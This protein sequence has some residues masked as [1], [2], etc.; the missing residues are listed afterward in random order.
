MGASATFFVLGATAI[1]YPH[2]IRAIADR[3]HEVACHGFWHDR[4]FAQTEA[5]FREDVEACAVLLEELTGRRPRGYR[6]PAFSI[7]SSTAWA[8]E[9]LADLGFEYD[10]SQYDSPRV[11][12]RHRAI[13]EA[14]Y[15]LRLPS[16]R[17]LWELPIATWR[18]G[19]RV[20]PIGGGSYWRLLPAAILK[21]ALRGASREGAPPMLYFHPYECDPRPLRAG[22]PPSA[23]PKARA[24]ALAWHLWF[25]PGRSRIV[26]R[27]ERLAKDFRLVGF[28][29]VREEISERYGA[30]TRSLSQG[31]VLV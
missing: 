14:P 25:N 29:E 26:P 1:H 28:E 2:A 3:G 19:E 21:R 6:A 22:V 4:V 15:R 17:E 7:T 31:G 30:G 23:G 13:P 9:V 5:D 12:G 27:L 20:M 16:G 11:R 18:R 24:M 8:Y 10:S